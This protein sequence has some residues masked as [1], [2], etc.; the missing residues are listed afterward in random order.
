MATAP[1]A[2]KLPPIRAGMGD[3]EAPSVEVWS[4]DDHR[5]ATGLLTIL[6]PDGKANVANVAN[7]DWPAMPAL[8]FEAARDAYRTMLRMRVLGERARAL[9]NEGRIAGYPNTRG[10]EAAIVGAAAAL[11]RGRRHRPRS[12]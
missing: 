1:R 3:V 7:V 10:A 8:S 6:S 11:A 12:A 4:D 9:V 5:R 2:D